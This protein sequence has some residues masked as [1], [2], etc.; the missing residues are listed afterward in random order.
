MNL[1][2]KYGSFRVYCTVY[3][4]PQITRCYLINFEHDKLFLFVWFDLFIFILYHTFQQMVGCAWNLNIFKYKKTT[5]LFYEAKKQ[6]KCHDILRMSH[7]I[8]WCHFHCIWWINKWWQKMLMRFLDVAFV[9]RH[10]VMNNEPA[11]WRSGLVL[12]V[13]LKGHIILTT[14][15]MAGG[16]NALQAERANITAGLGPLHSFWND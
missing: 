15:T 11:L 2:E 13:K 9:P 7:C 16:A 6:Q 14:W 1:L 4:Y 10:S 8:L 5:T 3:D 12:W